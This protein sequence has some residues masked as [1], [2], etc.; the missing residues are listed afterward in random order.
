MGAE[1]ALCVGDQLV[2]LRTVLA[3]LDDAGKR[4]AGHGRLFGGQREMIILHE[5]EADGVVEPGE[6]AFDKRR[7]AP[8]RDHELDGG[9]ADSEQAA[10]QRR[11][12]HLCVLFAIGS[13]VMLAGFPGPFDNFARQQAEAVVRQAPEAAVVE[14]TANDVFGEAQGCEELGRSGLRKESA[15][16][17]LHARETLLHNVEGINDVKIDAT[18]VEMRDDGGHFGAAFGDDGLPGLRGRGCAIFFAQSF[19]QDITGT[20]EAIKR[21]LLDGAGIAADADFLGKTE[22][23]HASAEETKSIEQGSDRF[24]PRFRNIDGSKESNHRV[25]WVRGRAEEAVDLSLRGEEAQ[26]K[27][28]EF[29]FLTGSRKQDAEE[30]VDGFGEQ[31][32]VAGHARFGEERNAIGFVEDGGDAGEVSVANFLGGLQDGEPDALAGPLWAVEVRK[33]GVAGQLGNAGVVFAEPGVEVDDSVQADVACAGVGEGFDTIGEFLQR[34]ILAR[35]GREERKK[36][37]SS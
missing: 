26:K 23:L 24:I 1:D 5:D 28:G 8:V 34:G 20:R 14:A 2:D 31:A 16:N 10:A 35:L 27:L 17:K 25:Q 7:P 30:A 3:I 29:G 19:H 33:E 36:E 37:F 21:R 9:G 15:G 11:F 6:K 22:A 12:P 13:D 4:G 18:R 32:A